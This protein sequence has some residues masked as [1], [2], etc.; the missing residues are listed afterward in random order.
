MHEYLYFS[1]QKLRHLRLSAYA[2]QQAYPKMVR[3]GEMIGDTMYGG[4]SSYPGSTGV[5][6]AGTDPLGE[7]M[8]SADTCAKLV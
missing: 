1:F 3:G 5:L 7:G 8:W 6:Q 2:N 4:P